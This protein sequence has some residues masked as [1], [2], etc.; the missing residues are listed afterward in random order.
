MLKS[1]KKFVKIASQHLRKKK[2]MTSPTITIHGI[3]NCDTM[4]KAFA[5]LDKH[6]VVYTFHD[7]KK[8][9]ADPKVLERAIKNHGWESVLNRK[10]ATWRALP[11]AV[12]ESMNDKSAL[13]A[14]LENPSIIRRP[15]IARENEITLGFDES[16]YKKAILR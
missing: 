10:G 9:G 14:A 15:M 11:D 5:W 13:K 7:Y 6:K 3:K 2:P 16:A 12:K 4:K 8:N 1:N